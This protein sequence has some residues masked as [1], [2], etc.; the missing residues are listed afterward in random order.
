[1][2][3]LLVEM[4]LLM[5]G[6]RN[7]GRILQLLQRCCMLQVGAPVALGVVAELSVLMQT[8]GPTQSLPASL[9]EYSLALLLW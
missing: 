1:M 9:C 6:D 3:K 8:N 2:E 5:K 7:S 4:G